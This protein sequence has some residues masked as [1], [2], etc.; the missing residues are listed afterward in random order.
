MFYKYNLNMRWVL[1]IYSVCCFLVAGGLLFKKSGKSTALLGLFTL[2]FG[3][4]IIDF[5][6][7]TS[8][9][10]L[11]YPQFFG[12]Y[13]LPAGFLYGPILLW[14]FRSILLQEYR[15]SIRQLTHLIPFLVVLVYLWPLFIMP[16]L[17]RI[18]Y[19]NEHFLDFI[20]PVN[21]ARASHLL[22]YGIILIDFLFKKRYQITAKRQ[23]FA[24]SVII[25]YFIS[26]VL[27]SWFTQFAS[28]WRDFDLYYF[29]AFNMVIIIGL[30]LY[31]DP[32]FLGVIAK[33]YLKSGI[34]SSD[35]TRIRKKIIATFAEQELFKRGDLSLAVLGSIIEEKSH[36]ISQVFSDEIEESFQSFVSRHRVEYAKQL[37]TD[38][39][40]RNYTI[41][42]I[43]QMA[44]FN[45]RV[46]F[47]NAFKQYTS[48]TPSYYQK[49]PAE[50]DRK[51]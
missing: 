45:N 29:T 9:L 5:L 21:Y 40:N 36:H 48:V 20:M 12:Y 26:C 10:K 51:L 31:T 30:L 32:A 38:P 46:S 44:G 25:I 23:L 34:S 13:Y 47:N 4:E 8:R 11:I 41:E 17:E 18:A 50:T 16:G 33:K 1:L 19:I 22:V 6:Y 35:K 49:N 2:M 42:A 15:F 28:G 14:Y 3:I 7:S 37:L 27:I 24:W 43:G 39:E